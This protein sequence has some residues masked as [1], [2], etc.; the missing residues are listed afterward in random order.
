MRID[1]VGKLEQ[2]YKS[3]SLQKNVQNVQKKQ[4]DCI[5]ISSFGRDMQ[6]AKKAVKEASD[7]RY[8]KVEDIKQRMASGTYNVSAQE[9]ADKMV[10][11][12]FNHLG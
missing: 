3:Q 12:Y 11:N 6:V 5:E 4:K 8:D 7:I 9:V 1:S 2:I 10:N